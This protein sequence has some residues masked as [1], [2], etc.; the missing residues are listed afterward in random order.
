LTN[1]DVIVVGGGPGG[2][3]AAY[4]HASLGKRVALFEKSQFPRDK[5]CGDAVTGKSLGILSEMGLK[6]E[7]MG[8]KEIST[9]SVLLTSPNATELNIPIS[10]PDDP[11]TSFCIE[12]LI[13]DDKIFRKASKVVEENGGE[14]IRESIKSPIVEGQKVI[15]VRNSKGK[16]Y[17]AE[18]V[19]GA[20]GY[21]CPLS[22]YVIEQNNLP[23]QDKSHYSSAI[24]E[25][26]TDL[27]CSEGA[28]EI[29]F[30]DEIQPGYFWIFPVGKNRY[31]VGVGM[32]LK[33]MD[34]KSVKLKGM[35]DRVI[36]NSRLSPIFEGANKIEGTR[37][38]WMLPLGGAKLRIAH[39]DG[40]RL[41]GDSASL[42]D[43]FTGEGIGN[44]LVSGK[45]SAIHQSGEDYQKALNEHMQSELANSERLQ[46]M[47]NHKRLVNWFFKKASRKPKLQQILTDMLHYKE[48]QNKF[49]SKL[50]WLRALLF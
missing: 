4:F 40:V 16:E 41:V 38:G 39:A 2:S 46:R 32:L 35:L 17:S 21:N 43:P 26:W 34:K 28:F 33:D 14:V 50:F 7:M 31:N 3:S 42:I 37:K 18:L 5:I 23:K 45:L 10:S 44:A 36:E 11:M 6:D 1:F 9:S 30:L 29:H 8:I 25:Y 12:R 24:R 22:R 13:F 49:G 48:K 20:G 15:G 47:L 27:N 19:I